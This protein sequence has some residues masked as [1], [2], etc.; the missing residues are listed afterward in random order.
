MC[1]LVDDIRD[2]IRDEV[3]GIDRVHLSLDGEEVATIARRETTEILE[4][5]NNALREAGY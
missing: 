3:S 2:L 4:G 1:W 5:L